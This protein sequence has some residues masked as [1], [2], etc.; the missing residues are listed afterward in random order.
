MNRKDLK[1]FEKP[2]QDELLALASKGVHYRILDGGHVRLYPEDRTKRPF[3][4]S[5]HRPAR[6]SLHYIR[7][8]FEVS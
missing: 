4:V 2:V 3:K 1:A 6:L 5:A 8:Q 7:T